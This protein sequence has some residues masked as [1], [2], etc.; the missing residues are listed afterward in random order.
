MH[1]ILGRYVEFIRQPDVARMLAIALLSRMPIGMV[2]FAMVMY[3]REA[4]GDF[5]LAGSAV[6]IN[7][8]AMAAVAPIVGRS[9]DRFGPRMPLLITGLVQ[10]FALAGVL[11]SAKLGLGFAYVAGAAALS[12][13]FASPITTLTRTAWRQRFDREEDRRTAFSVD[14]VMIELNFTVG[15]VIV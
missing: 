7:F 9:V 4:L 10:P 1:S 12:G 2:G 13:M 6:G 14:A 8:V 5:A 11:V 3:L 15:P